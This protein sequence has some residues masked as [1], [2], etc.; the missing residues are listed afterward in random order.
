MLNPDA[1]D[2]ILHK[3]ALQ[4]PQQIVLDRAFLK[5]YMTSTTNLR[6]AVNIDDIDRTLLSNLHTIYL[7]KLKIKPNIIIILEKT[8]KYNNITTIILS[9]IEFP[10]DADATAFF[11]FLRKTP[12]N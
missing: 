3:L 1:I 2:N 9:T 11:S 10:T 8:L 7:E 5:F 12:Q 4:H 6:G